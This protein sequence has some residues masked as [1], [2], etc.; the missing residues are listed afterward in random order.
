VICPEGFIH[1][2][3]IMP[4]ARKV[5][6]ENPLL[7][8]LWSCKSFEVPRSDFARAQELDLSLGVTGQTALASDLFGLGQLEHALASY[9]LECYL[10]EDWLELYVCGSDLSAMRISRDIL[11]WPPGAAQHDLSLPVGNPYH[12]ALTLLDLIKSRPERYPCVEIPSWRLQLPPPGRSR[13]EV[14]ERGALAEFLRRVTSPLLMLREADLPT[15]EVLQAYIEEQYE[16]QRV[17]LAYDLRPRKRGRPPKQSIACGLA[18][19]EL[20][21]NGRPADKSWK[22][23]LIEVQR[24]LEANGFGD[25]K[26][27]LIT[28][29][30]CAEKAPDW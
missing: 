16:Q 11:H 15:A 25:G 27:T 24:Y 9:L 12:C 19:A 23:I 30:R 10:L 3:Q 20:Y 8:R 1:V 4:L 22:E 17:L 13:V 2:Q 29:R 28:L 26:V 5:A 7:A 18:L 6:A 21:P 14:A